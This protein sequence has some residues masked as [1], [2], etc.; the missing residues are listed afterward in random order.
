M[1][2]RVILQVGNLSFYDHG[3]KR[4]SVPTTLAMYSFSCETVTGFSA[5]LLFPPKSAVPAALSVHM[6]GSP[7]QRFR[8]GRAFFS[9][10]LI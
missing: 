7:K 10:F 8:E 3:R 2:G 5:I 4:G 9:S 1:S 6:T